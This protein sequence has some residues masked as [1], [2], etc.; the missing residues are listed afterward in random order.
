M[1]RLY[2]NYYQDT[3]PE[4]QKELD[5]CLNTN[6]CNPLIDKIY[7]LS[8][9]PVPGAVHIPFTE[10]PTF[11]H[12]FEIINREALPDD[13]SIIAN[14]DI[15]FDATLNL[16]NG[17][18]PHQVY[19]LSRTDHLSWDSQDAWIFRGPVKPVLG[20]FGLG[21]PGCDNRIAYVLQ[22]AGYNVTNPAMSI[23]A[24]HVHATQIRHY[25]EHT[26]KVRRPYLLV[27]PTKFGLD[28]PKHIVQ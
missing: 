26:Q 9:S 24:T 7:T 1:I 21:I 3:F 19:A 2:V 27:T 22:E 18:H 14:T 20:D 15:H 10:R 25:N 17:M 16:V 4:R 13:I 5:Y 6:L 12:F 8:E 28:S 23:Q 11:N